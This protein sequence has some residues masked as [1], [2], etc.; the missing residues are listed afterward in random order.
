[1]GTGSSSNKQRQTTGAFS[2]IMSYR[3]FLTFSQD[4]RVEAHRKD[5]KERFNRTQRT[6]QLL[7]RLLDVISKLTNAWERFNSRNGDIGYFAP[8][9]L[10]VNAQ[11]PARRSLFEIN[12]RFEILNGLQRDLAHLHQNNESSA[13]AVRLHQI[14]YPKKRQLTRNQ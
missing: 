10:P 3:K 7:R 12:Q 13:Q 8:H 2:A 6:L 14:L 11:L 4:L 9:S 1:M 5:L